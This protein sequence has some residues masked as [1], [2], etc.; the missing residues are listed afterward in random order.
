MHL[1]RPLTPIAA[2]TF[3]LD[4]TLYDNGPVITRA[5]NNMWDNLARLHPISQQLNSQQWMEIKTELGETIPMLRHDVTAWRQ[6]FLYTGL[7]KCGY[8]PHQA[9]V[10]TNELMSLF[11]DDRCRVDMPQETHQVLSEL[12]KKIPLVAITNGNVDF[13]RIGLADYFKF[14]LMAGVDGISKPDPALYNKA[15]DLLQ[16]EASQILHVGDHLKTDVAGSI[17]AGYQAC[18]FNDHQRDIKK[19]PHA[20]LLPNIEIS[21]LTSLLELV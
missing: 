6:Q 8:L 14:S 20:S 13:K 17:K 1:Y 16:I 12:A 10:A 21:S 3:D 4:D 19:E 15:A 5:V 2:M 11:M 18:W 7:M 9:E